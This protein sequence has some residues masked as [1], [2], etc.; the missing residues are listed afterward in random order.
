MDKN[1]RLFVFQ[2]VIEALNENQHDEEIAENF[3]KLMESIKEDSVIEDMP[4][5]QDYLSLF[6]VERAFDGYLFVAEEETMATRDD[7]IL[8]FKLIAASFSSSYDILYDKSSNS[9]DF[10]ITVKVGDQSLTRRVSELFFPQIAGLY[11][12]YID[13]QASLYAYY[14]NPDNTQEITNERKLRLLVFEKKVRQLHDLEGSNEILSDLDD[15]LN[16]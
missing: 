11:V 6:D 15:L 12:N 3:N 16:S 10:M 4:F 13:E 7:L 9:I 5:Y 14:I 8:L 1:Y 2:S